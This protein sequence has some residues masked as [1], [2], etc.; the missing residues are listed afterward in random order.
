MEDLFS[1]NLKK[2][3]P[4]ADRMRPK[5][6]DE[7]LGQEHIV[8]KNTLLRRA[9]EADKLG[10]CIF[11]GPPGCGKSTLA[12]I[13]A[14]TTGSDFYK[15]NA[16]T[17][18]VKDVREV[19]DEAESNLKMYGRESFLL[20]DECH[21]WSKS[22]SDSV[23]PAMESG[24]IKLI[25]ST[26]ENPMAAMTSAIVSR[27]RL[28]EFYGLT[29][30]D[31]KK[32]VYRAAEDQENGFGNMDLTLDE[33]AVEHWA[34]VSNGDIRSALNALEL[35]V[36]T[37][38]PDKKG[39]VHITL[40]IA[41]QSIQQR[42]VRMDDNEY[43]DMLSA[44]CKSLRGSDSDAALFWFARM[45]YAGVDPRVPVRRMIAHASEDVGL[46]N[47]SVLNQCVAAMQALD[48]NGM[49]EARLNI[50]QAIIYLC[51][52]PKSNSV[53]LAVDSAARA[54]REVKRQNVPAHLQDT[55][56]EKAKHEQKGKQYKYAHDYP[57]HYVQQQYLPDEL[58][59]TVFYKPSMQGYE[60]K[61]HEYRRFT[62]KEKKPE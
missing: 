13:I 26:T 32:A 3:A 41:E 43:Y 5:T 35:A 25:G 51:E 40:E 20:L 46:A 49:P 15:L 62:G 38:K 23:L 17:S 52:S 18:G 36:L 45:I 53:L 7:F 59:G 33:D 29:E 47:P 12:A 19:I 30:E 4:L 39:K 57:R 11:W 10:S 42:A 58:K 2:N 1:G 61:V 27:C 44:F 55:N 56:F 16:V 60:Q 22:Q 14:Q 54:A 24:V 8:G 21:R 37:T 9:I 28:F 48:F 50:A 31:V 6:L 34:S